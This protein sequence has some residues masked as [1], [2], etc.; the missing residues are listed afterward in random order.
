MGRTPRAFTTVGSAAGSIALGKA[1]SVEAD[2][3]LIVF[4]HSDLE[5]ALARVG[6][7][8]GTLTREVF[9]FPGG[10]CF[11]FSDPSGNEFAVWSE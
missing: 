5:G 6:K 11:H 2:P 7:L 4:Y 8:G 10:R 3:P 9:S 1:S